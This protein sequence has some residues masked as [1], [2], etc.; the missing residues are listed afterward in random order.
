MSKCALDY[1]CEIFTARPL[2]KHISHTWNEASVFAEYLPYRVVWLR[3]WESMLHLMFPPGGY[4]FTT[5]LH[6]VSFSLSTSRS[7]LWNSSCFDIQQLPFYVQCVFWKP[8]KQE[9]HLVCDRTCLKPYQFEFP[10]DPDEL[11][12]SLVT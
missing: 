5:F 3:W 7:W 10:L 8:S 12:S 1:I 4:C 11:K 2:P 9:Q 6:A